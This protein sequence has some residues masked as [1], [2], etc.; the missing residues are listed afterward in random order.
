ML[1]AMP[2]S[3]QPP[4]KPLLPPLTTTQV[5]P[6]PLSEAERALNQNLQPETR[7]ATPPRA[8]APRNAAE[9]LVQNTRAALGTPKARRQAHG[10]A[11]HR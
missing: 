5:T 8:P 6:K 1:E 9:E 2:P 3:E 11:L 7:F 4:L 10:L